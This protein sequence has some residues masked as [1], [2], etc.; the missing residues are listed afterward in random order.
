M[1]IPAYLTAGP[2]THQRSWARYSLYLLTIIATLTTTVVLVKNTGGGNSVYSYTALL[3]ALL[4]A[5][6]FGVPGG[7]LTALLGA[8]ALG[9]HTPLNTISENQ[10]PL[11]LWL[12]RLAV[13]VFIG[14]VAGMLH[15]R[16][17][18]QAQAAIETERR[19]PATMLP[20]L[21]ALRA[22]LGSSLAKRSATDSRVAVLL[23][24][25]T[26]L[27]EIIDVVGLESGDKAMRE[28]AHHLLNTCPEVTGVYRFSGSHLALVAKTRDQ[29]ALKRLARTLHN[30]ASASFEVD[31]APLRIEPALGI[32]HL[33][34]EGAGS[35]DELI[36]RARVALRHAMAMDKDWVAYEPTIETD[37]AKTVDLIARV[38]RALSA[39]E[40]ELHYQPKMRLTD[41]QP[42]GAEALARWRQPSGEIVPPGSFMPKLEHTSLIDEF[43]GFVIRTATDYARTNPLVPVSINLAARNLRDE[44]LIDA[45]LDGL[46]KT[47]TPPEHFEVEVTESALMRDPEAAIQQLHR[48][49]EAGIGVCI[50][51]FGTGYASFSYLRCLPVT[52][53]K[54]DREFIRP[55]EGDTRARRLVMAMVDVGHALG[56]TVTAEGI[57]TQAQARILADIGCDFGQGFLWSAAR[58]AD[59]L[60][61]W[62][63]TNRARGNGSIRHKTA[64]YSAT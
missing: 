50:D 44:R 4:G 41:G 21:Y 26:D 61:S 52:N 1:P 29:Q 43:S 2:L 16:L 8:L 14:A 57:E 6:W 64:N 3:P 36:R 58:P 28:L 19:D 7:V 60:Q 55:L 22:E 31:G 33:G 63:D 23:L 9:L 18:R 34:A 54:I 38:E 46:R 39:N 53:L 15:A 30:A 24:S 40:F 10:P 62:L 47:G 48:L 35:V 20:N 37:Q 49:R 12:P 5:A 56:L 25:A 45:L 42:V 13:F 59:E 11:A 51:D 27:D 17:W 32:G